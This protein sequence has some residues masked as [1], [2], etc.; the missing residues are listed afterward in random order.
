MSMI[1][2]N[3]GANSRRN[4]CYDDDDDDNDDEGEGKD[5]RVW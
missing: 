2:G 3:L 4:N 5:G 1:S